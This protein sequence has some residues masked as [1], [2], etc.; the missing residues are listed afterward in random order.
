M[1]EAVPSYISI[2]LKTG[3][4]LTIYTEKETE[5]SILAIAE[6]S[7]A[8]VM[9][10]PERITV[11]EG[12]FYQ[13]ITEDVKE[14]I[15]GLSYKENCTVPYEDLNYVGVLYVDFQGETQTGELI[16][17]K[18]IAKD[19]AEIFKELYENQ[20]PIDKI[21]LVDEYNADDDLSCLDN[22]TSCF[23][24]RVVGGT[25][26]LSKHALGLAVDINPFYN[27]YVTYPNGVERISPP[28]SEPYGD[29]SADFPYKIDYDD[30]C[31]QL[32]TAHGFTW[33]GDWKSLKDYQHF[34]KE[35]E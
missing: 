18:G 25:N 30:L 20:Y 32:F 11:S 31:Y 3:E 28:G 2:V 27:P 16:C 29:R 21:R 5:Q 12:F 35:L 24:F 13:P 23:N 15:Y 4:E 10:S 1:K 33:G 26:N 14:R 7:K 17:N 22:N 34:Q 6:E 19:L 9:E 8:L